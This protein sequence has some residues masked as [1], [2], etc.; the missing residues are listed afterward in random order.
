MAITTTM[1]GDELYRATNEQNHAATIDMR[2]AGEK[3]GLSPTELLLS[4]LAGCVGVDVVHMLKKRRKTITHFEIVTDGT[5]RDTPPRYFTH[6][7]SLYRVTSPDVEPE[8]LQ[9]VTALAME[10]YCSVGGSLKSELTFSV[11]VIRP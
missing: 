10:K 1:L 3:E 2:P 4:A 7:H 5:R 11:E 9:K 6:I 8:E